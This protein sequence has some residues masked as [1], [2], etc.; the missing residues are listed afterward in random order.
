[1]SHA[2]GDDLRLPLIWFVIIHAFGADDGDG[3]IQIP[4]DV[5]MLLRLAPSSALADCSSWL[6]SAGVVD[7]MLKMLMKYPTFSQ[8]Q[9]KERGYHIPS[10]ERL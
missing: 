3:I 10:G 2:V 4:V 5:M 1:L 6:K 9:A 8:D 7:Q